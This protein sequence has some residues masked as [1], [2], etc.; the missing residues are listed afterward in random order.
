MRLPYPQAREEVDRLV[1]DQPEIDASRRRTMGVL[2]ALGRH[3]ESCIESQT[4]VAVAR[5]ALGLAAQ[6]QTAGDYPADLAELAPLFPDGMPTD[7]RVEGPLG[8]RHEEDG[9]VTLVPAAGREGEIPGRYR[10]DP[11]REWSLQP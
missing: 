7:P 1:A 2:L 4:L 3:Y 11:P 5:V 6:R 8:Y 10:A 9:R